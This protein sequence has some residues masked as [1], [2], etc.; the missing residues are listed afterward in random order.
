MTVNWNAELTVSEEQHDRI[1]GALVA[2]PAP[3]K[4]K[5]QRTRST[6][7]NIRAWDGNLQQNTAKTLITHE[8]DRHGNVTLHLDKRIEAQPLRNNGDNISHGEAALHAVS[9]GART[10]AA[11]AHKHTPTTSQQGP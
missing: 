8:A 11:G 6:F 2:M 7:R 1:N 4:H 10:A 9:G 3:R 5:P